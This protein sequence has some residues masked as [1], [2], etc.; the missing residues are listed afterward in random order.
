MTTA[1]VLLGVY[2]AV[3]IHVFLHEREHVRAFIN[4]GIRPHFVAIGAP[5]PFLW[6]FYWEFRHPRFLYGIP[7]RIYPLLITGACKLDLTQLRSL[8]KC[9][10][11][12]QAEVNSAGIWANLFYSFAGFGIW[13][14]LLGDWVRACVFV[15]LAVGLLAAKRI[16][17][18]YLC[19]LLTLAVGVYALPKM[20]LTVFSSHPAT[21]ITLVHNVGTSMQSGMAWEQGLLYALLAGLVLGSFN[22]LPIL[23]LDGGRIVHSFLKLRWA[24]AAQMYGYATIPVSLAIVAYSLFLEAYAL[25]K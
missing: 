1:V 20:L 10:F 25:F 24:K 13:F 11:S 16:F 2:F 19:P 17:L 21:D 23:P 12:Q 22:L 8:L 9:K 4:L 6:N 14:V 15:T 18:V 7:M 5:I 3:C